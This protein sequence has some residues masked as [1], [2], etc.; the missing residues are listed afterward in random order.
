MQTESNCKSNEGTIEFETIDERF[1][2]K[3]LLCSFSY[4]TKELCNV[5]LN[6]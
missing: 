3:Y 5:G 4:F 6:N 1:A 2:N